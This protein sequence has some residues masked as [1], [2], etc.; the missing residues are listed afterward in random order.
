MTEHRKAS[1]AY[2]LRRIRSTPFPNR[3]LELVIKL[4]ETQ[5]RI[6]CLIVRLTLGWHSGKTDARRASVNLTYRQILTAIGRSSPTIV[7][8]AVER[9]VILGIV[10][11]LTDEGLVLKT[12]GERRRHFR[13]L[14]YRLSRKF[15]E[16]H[17]LR[18]VD[19][20]VDIENQSE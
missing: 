19:K 13:P 20:S 11:V 12:P 18:S 14:C 15:V 9:L 5:A 10:E 4:P 6:V 2:S 16:T 8:A 17:R 3:L 1:D 7:G